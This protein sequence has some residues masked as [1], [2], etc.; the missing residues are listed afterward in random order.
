MKR[1]LPALL[2]AGLATLPGCKSWVYLGDHT[3][4]VNAP[5][6]VHRGD[7]FAFTVFVKDR[8]GTDLRKV[9]Y[10]WAIDWVGVQ[11]STHK[12]KSGKQ[13]EIRVKGSPGTAT[14]HILGYDANDVF[15]EI[16][17]HAFQ[18]E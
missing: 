15:G 7:N 5:S 6:K 4:T 16:A 11:G 3:V 12:G 2:V 14:L 13:E 10:E 8:A 9:E 18:V 17:R 1:I